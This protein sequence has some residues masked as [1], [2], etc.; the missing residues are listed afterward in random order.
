MT[1]V[2]VQSHRD[3]K[4]LAPEVMTSNLPA[5]AE[6]EFSINPIAIGAFH[7]VE[8]G[9][10]VVAS[11]GNDG[12]AP[13]SVVNVAPW[14]FTVGAKPIDRNI[15][16]HIP[17]GGN[18]L[19]KGGGISFSNLKK[20]PVYPLADSVSVKL[21]SE[22]YDGPAS[23]CKQDTLDERKVKGKTI[24]CDYADDDFS[25]ETRLNE[26]KKK[27]GIGVI[28]SMPDDELI[29][30]P[31]MGSF[32][33][34]VITQGDG[35]KIRSY[36]DSTRNPVATILPPAPVMAFFSSRCPTYNTRNL[37]KLDI[38][39]PGTAIVA[40]WHPDDAEVTRSGQK[41]PLFNIDS[42][43]EAQSRGHSRICRLDLTVI[44]NGRSGPSWFGMLVTARA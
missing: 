20:S 37:L 12:P 24:V 9:I 15:E 31:K 26:V 36:I 3:G 34:A 19:I 17:L 33:G 10:F 5:A 25:V 6:F 28:L 30:A 44:E 2:S 41:P 18:K 22:F 42:G 8:K 35:I 1:R 43:L 16:T 7:A 32:P 29:T 23:D 21:D 11:A 40:A 14:I 38:A 4:E 13:E 39:A 27:G